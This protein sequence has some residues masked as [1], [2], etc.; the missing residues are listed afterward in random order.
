MRSVFSLLACL[1]LLGCSDSRRGTGGNGG[2]GGG[3]TG[4]GGGFAGCAT[5]QFAANPLPAAML[6]VLD[7]SSSMAE[8]S[9]WIS[10]AQAIVQALDA[11]AFD[12]MY[13]GL[14]AAPSGDV[15]GPECILGTPVACQ[16]PPF[17]EVDLALA[18]TMKSSA[19]GVRGMIKSWLNS[20]APD[21]GAG[22]AS[23]MYAGLQAA[24]GALKAWSPPGGGA[25]KRILLVVTDGTLSC[26]QFSNRPGYPDCNGCNHDWEDPDNLVQLVGQAN[27][28]GVD[29]FVVGVPGA[30]T[31][32][33]SGCNYPP[34]HMRLA[35][36][37][38]AAA[39][40]PSY[41]P[42]SCTGTT[43]SQGGAD[44]QVSCHFDM[45]QG[46]FS[47]SALA[48]TMATVRGQ[49]L[50]CTFALPPAPGGGMLD[51]TQVN[52]EY[53]VNGGPTLDLYKR[54]DPTNTCTQ[55]GC[56]DW[57]PDGKVQLVGKACDDVKLA[58]N[59]NVQIVVGCATV[60]Q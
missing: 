52:V 34:Y 50:G 21:N 58:Q 30:D 20:N 41:T 8:G 46:N 13:V 19:G 31:F 15:T 43:Y 33:S 17:P 40:A 49:V 55:T 48:D 54:A 38:I 6:V 12:S 42:S 56:W 28:D 4:G 51:P 59:A 36:S 7:R 47:T 39:G 10:A 9:K 26:N 18:G 29:T 11:D 1:A 22:D 27:T 37:A 25:A 16:A 2:T 53:S 24:I 5:A 35:L 45:T 32:D 14:Y 23:P 44:P 57:T 3:G 60:I